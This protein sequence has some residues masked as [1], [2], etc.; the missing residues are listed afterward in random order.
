[1]IVFVSYASEQQSVAVEIAL[2]LRGE[3]HEVFLD[4]SALPE[5]DAYNARIREAIQSCDLIVFLLSPEAVS[6]GRYTLTELK[7]A[8]EK[9]PSPV[10]RVLPVAVRPTD[11]AAIPAY[12]GAVVILRPR[13]NVAAEV[14]AA[15]DR[16]SKPW[17]IQLVRRHAAWLIGLTVLGGGAGG[18]RTYEHWR[19]CAGTAGLVREARLEQGAGD[20]ASAWDRYADAIASCPSSDEATVGREHLA[21]E[22]LDNIRVTEGKETFTDVVK[23]VQPALSA[24]AVA[25]DDRRAADAL[26][27]LGWADFLRTRDGT[28]GLNPVHYY[29]QA[30]TRD[31]QNPFAHAMWAHH[32]LWT[33]GPIDEARGHFNKALASGRE[34]SYVRNMELH[35]FLSRRDPDG[36]NEVLRVVNEMRVQGEALP[37]G[38]RDDSLTWRVWDVYYGRLVRGNDRASFLA[39]VSPK[40]QLAT[41]TWLFPEGVVPEDKRPLYLFML[42]QLQEN[43]GDRTDALATY[44]SLLNLLVARKWDSAMAPQAREAI[45]RLRRG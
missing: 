18:W 38:T 14:V 33:R 35:G 28:G 20:Y 41:I 8:E 5:G 16:L 40:D 36:E 2:A 12:L 26:A 3:G 30:V 13:G 7:F 42:A 32:V 24:G 22:W 29:Q 25:P 23:K 34:R 39:A 31:S 43:V 19:T 11:K 45:K 44:E 4:R 27:H 15:V 17:W 6:E 9:W 10:G 37:V 1:M 21:M